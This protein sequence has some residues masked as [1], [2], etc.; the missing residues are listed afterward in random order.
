MDP[1]LLAQRNA[2]VTHAVDR[3][4]TQRLDEGW[5]SRMLANP[6]TR[7]V[8]VWQDKLL[9]QA[10]STGPLSRLSPDD[11]VALQSICADAEVETV[12]LGTLGGVTYGIVMLATKAITPEMWALLRK[13]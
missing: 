2:F 7:F 1:F 13:E 8:V 4:H 6:A 5:F 9:V 3:T 10:G 11:M 12:L